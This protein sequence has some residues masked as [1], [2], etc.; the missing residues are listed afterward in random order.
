MYTCTFF[1]PIGTLYAQFSGDKIIRLTASELEL[2]G[3]GTE[4]EIMT[5]KRLETELCEYFS[6]LRRSFTVKTAPVGT[7]FQLKVWREMEKIPYGGTM[8]YGALAEKCGNKN[9]SRAVGGACN[10]NPVLILIPCH[11]VV[12][13]D[14]MG[15]FA[16]GQEKKKFLLE[17]EK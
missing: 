1:T 10:K 2:S 8:T 4:E 16:L 3:E 14:S 9:A 15:G 5:A 7:P 12:A 17:R 11:R 13:A 6:G